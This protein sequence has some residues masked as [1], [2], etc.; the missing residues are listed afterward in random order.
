ML[1]MTGFGGGE[2]KTGPITVTVELRSVNHRF[3]DISL[4]LPGSLA[5]FEGDIRKFLKDNV[6]RGRVTV[7]AQL[8]LAREPEDAGLDPDR[9]A[10][11]LAMV[12]Q[13]ARALENETGEKQS[14]TLDHLLN[15][16]DLFRAEDLDLSADDLREALM[17]AMTQAHRD[18]MKMKDAE[19]K[20]LVNEMRQRLDTL[21]SQLAA[22]EKL[23]PQAGAEIQA[24]LEERLAKIMTE[25]IDPQR[26][27]QEVALLADKANINEECERLGIH[28]DHFRR[29]LDEGGQVAKRLNF[30]LQEMHREVN[31][32]GSKTNLMDITQAV[33][34]MKDEVESIREQIQNLE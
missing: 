17:S 26:L 21:T 12:R 11:G 22:V 10:Q 19:G 8:Q 28:I 34:T 13:A 14:V 20:A 4:K 9:L 33:I 7:S 27:A 24:R 2:G 25:Q 30:L 31:T 23:A 3:L 6:A 16:P 1:S 32:M 18:L 29:A 15:V 5:V